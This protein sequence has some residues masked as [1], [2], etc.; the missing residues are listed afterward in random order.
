MI[1]AG[2]LAALLVAFGEDDWYGVILV[3]LVALGCIF[4]L[5]MRLST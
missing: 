4:A 5:F 1:I 2:S 3:S